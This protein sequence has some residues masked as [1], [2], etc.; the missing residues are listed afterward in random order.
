VAFE[1]LAQPVGVTT[2]N[3]QVRGITCVRT[4]LN[5]QPEPVPDSEFFLPATQII[6]AIGQNRPGIAQQ[7]G[8]KTESGLISVDGTLETSLPGVFAGGDCIRIKG[9]AS[10]VMAVQDGKLAASAIHKK[11]MANG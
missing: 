5:P 2:F 4:R 8:L 9:A 7:L 3:R 1:F 10:T 6:K 11:V